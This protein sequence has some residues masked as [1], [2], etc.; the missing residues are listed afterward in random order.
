MRT[1]RALP[2]ALALA[3]LAAC[4]ERDAPTASHVSHALPRA[5]V[6][7]RGSLQY[8]GYAG[9]DTEQASLTG[10]ESYA[11]FQ[12]VLTDDQKG[13]IT[14][15]TATAIDLAASHNLKATVNLAGVFWN[16]QPNTPITLRTDYASRWNA[17]K[18]ANASAL[19]SDKVLAFFILDEPVQSGVN[20][21]AWQTAAAL[22]KS[23]FP[24][25]PIGVVEAA[26]AVLTVA[27]DASPVIT[28][29]D[30]VGVDLYPIHPATNA[31][32]LNARAKMKARYP[33]KRWIY[34]AD[35]FWNSAGQGTVFGPVSSMGSAMQEYYDVARADADAILL[36]TF[37]WPDLR[38]TAGN[39]TSLGSRSFP[40]SAL[41]RHTEVGR[42]IT[43]RT[44]PSTSLP[45]GALDP[46]TSTTV[47]GWACDPDAAWGEVVE[48]RAYLNG[49]LIATDTADLQNTGGTVIA[50]CRTGIFRRFSITVPST[51]GGLSVVAKD[52]SSTA[53]A[54]IPLVRGLWIQP[55]ASAGFGPP[56]SLVV[57]G[58]ASGAAAGTVV[59]FFWRDVTAAGA[60]TQEPYTPTPDANG[61]W[62]HSIPNAV[63]SH[64]Y[65]VFAQYGGLQSPTCTYFGSNA[66]TTC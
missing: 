31:T 23:S 11:N 61:I 3:A 56:G 13:A 53:T 50:Q 29:V 43:L 57:A 18:A 19:T 60:W 46:I 26:P 44:R 48:V 7:P 55:Q 30:W 34:V 45:V 20:M 16:L 40:P 9:A 65:A 51:F 27:W 22:V 39:V 47:S 59:R 32:F 35:G 62:Y 66:Y 52:L 58:N 4:A 36:G 8:F 42:A 5:T 38:D 24:W 63:Y 6:G 17:W 33:G 25:A 28:T 64:R 2:I 12:Q 41:A 14:G 49:S 54:G 15:S 1:M 10:L 37:I 21:G